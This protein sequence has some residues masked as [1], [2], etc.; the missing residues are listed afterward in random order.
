[1][2]SIPSRVSDRLAKGIKTFQPIIQSAKARDV[3]ESDT[4]IIVTDMLCYL[5]GY[6]KYSEITSEYAIRGTYCDLATKLDGRVQ[7]L[8]EVKSIG[9]ELKD[10]H[11]RQAVDYAV[12]LGVEWVALTNGMAWRIYKVCFGKPVTQEI[13]VE[14]NFLDLNPK[15]DQ[16]LESLFLLAKEGWTR[17]AIGDYH[18][19]QQALSRYSLA[20]AVLS[21]YVLAAVR[22]ELRRMSPDVRIDLPQIKAALAQEVLK[23]EVMEGDKADEARRRLN[24]ADLKASRQKAANNNGSDTDAEPTVPEQKQPA[25]VAVADKSQK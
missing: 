2:A 10:S 19:Q 6:E 4:V 24:R 11:V 23:R 12:N 8:V 1:M 21:D 16:H 14:F 25:E 22:H 17:S 13:V 9:T 7:C 3:N 20:A 15:N 5:F 18:I